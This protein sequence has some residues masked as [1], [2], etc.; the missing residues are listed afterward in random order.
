MKI[1]NLIFA[2]IFLIFATLQYNDPDPFVWI[3]IYGMMTLTCALAAW[4]KFY[5]KTA[6]ALALIYLI[7]AV[8][9]APSAWRLFTSN[10]PSLL[11]DGLAKMQNTYIEETRECL[12]LLT[13]LA[14]LAIDYFFLK[15]NFKL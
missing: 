11:F 13:C 12:G 7:Y 3:F 10:E 5:N 15:K 8:A 14:V 4:G 2:F 1:F 9:L 6:L